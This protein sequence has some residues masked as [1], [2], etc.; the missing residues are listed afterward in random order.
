M[1]LL[2]I[3]FLKKKLKPHWKSIQAIKELVNAHLNMNV[4]N[5]AFRYNHRGK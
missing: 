4:K 1:H 3:K 2:H 5:E